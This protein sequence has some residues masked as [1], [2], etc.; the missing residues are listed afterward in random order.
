MVCQEDQWHSSPHGAGAEAGEAHTAHH[1]ANGSERVRS[2]GDVA[3]VAEL[4]ELEPRVEPSDRE[5]SGSEQRGI[6]R[7]VG[8]V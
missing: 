3:R 4:A 5:R 7:P 6:Y 1:L 2:V 8:E